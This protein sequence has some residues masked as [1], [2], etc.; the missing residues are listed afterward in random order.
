MIPN[1]FGDKSAFSEV[2]S[3]PYE[4]MPRFMKN[5]IKST[6]VKNLFEVQ[7]P[8]AKRKYMETQLTF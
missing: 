6:P 7:D 5:A 3:G 4:G 2:A 8:R 1:W